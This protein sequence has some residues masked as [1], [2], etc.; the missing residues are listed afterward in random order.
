VDQLLNDHRLPD[1][2]AAEEPDL[3]AADERGDQ[4]DDLDP[5]LEDLRRRRQVA[6]RRRIAV[7]RPALGVCGRRL[8]LVDWIPEHVP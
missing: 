7:N 8:L 5:R 2:C 6:E 3:A 4:V 1:A